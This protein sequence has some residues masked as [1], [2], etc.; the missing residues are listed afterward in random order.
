VFG[1]PTAIPSKS[2]ALPGRAER[3]PVPDAHFVNIPNTLMVT[4]F[5]DLFENAPC[6]QR[7]PST[8]QVCRLPRRGTCFLPQSRAAYAVGGYN[9]HSVRSNPPSSNFSPLPTRTDVDTQYS[10]VPPL[11]QAAK[12]S[13]AYTTVSP[14]LLFPSKVNN[15]MQSLTPYR[16]LYSTSGLFT[17]FSKYYFNFRSRY[18][19]A[20]DVVVILSFRREL[21]PTLV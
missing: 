4:T 15:C 13:G 6:M 19:F 17:F 14:A 2:E 18:F 5:A 8:R 9:S 11:I 20:I 1:K 3:M 16:S 7:T 12:D 10:Q 21:P